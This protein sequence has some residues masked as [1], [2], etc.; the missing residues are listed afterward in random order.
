MI[1]IFS[2]IINP[3]TVIVIIIPVLL[4]FGLSKK[5]APPNKSIPIINIKIAFIIFSLFNTIKYPSEASSFIVP[6]IL[7]I[8]IMVD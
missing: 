5:T 3:K 2:I 1:S 7:Y 6:S 8:N 4:L